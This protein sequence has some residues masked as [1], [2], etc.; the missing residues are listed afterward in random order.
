MPGD[1]ILPVGH[2]GQSGEHTLGCLRDGKPCIPSILP[3][4][5]RTILECQTTHFF[6]IFPIVL[7][8]TS[9]YLSASG[10]SP[11]PT[12]SRTIQI[13]RSI[14]M[15]F[16]YGMRYGTGSKETTHAKGTIF[17]EILST[18]VRETKPH[19]GLSRSTMEDRSITPTIQARRSAA[20]HMNSGKYHKQ[21]S[22]KRTL[23]LQAS[24]KNPE[25]Q[26]ISFEPR[27]S[28]PQQ[29]VLSHGNHNTHRF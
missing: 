7:Q 9:P 19:A 28:I 11:M 13:T 12:L 4:P 5:S 29:P 8:P 25:S 26:V 14:M 3:R 21:K 24:S 17:P 1:R 27:L 22:L 15:D 16:L 23:V 20:P 10:S 18:T 2:L 6:E